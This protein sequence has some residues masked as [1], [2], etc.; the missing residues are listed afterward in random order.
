MKKYLL[1]SALACFILHT[2][3]II[4]SAQISC[5]INFLN[6][7]NGCSPWLLAVNAVDTSVYPIIQRTWSL[8]TCNGTPIFTSAAGLNPSYTYMLVTDTCDCYYLTLKSENSNGDTAV[9]ISNPINVYPSPQFNNPYVVPQAGCPTQTVTLYPN[10][11]TSC[12][13]IDS[14]IIEWGCYLPT[15]LSNNLGSINHTY[16]TA[17][18][19]GYRSIGAIAM[20]RTVAR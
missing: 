10:L 15:H 19:P 4:V 3:F 11:T 2:S 8:K 7:N 20:N 1:R 9:S 12:G 16:D 6:S 5:S 14:L 18:L 17:C 13:I